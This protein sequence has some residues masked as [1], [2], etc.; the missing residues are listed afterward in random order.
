M[1]EYP[2]NEMIQK[3]KDALFSFFKEKYNWITYVVL[4]VLVFLA[5]RIRSLNLDKL[6]DITTGTWTLGPDLDPFLFLRWAKYIV[7][8]G[9]LFAVDTM[10]YVPLGYPTDTELPLLAYSIAWFHKVAVIFGSE[11]VTQSAVLFPVFIF[12]LTV[13]AFFFFVRK[14]FLDFLGKTKANIIALLSSFFLIILPDFLPRTIAGIPEK[15]SLAFFFM[16]L[17]FYLFLCAWKTERLRNK[18]VL[19]VLAGISTAGMG[20]TWGGVGYIFLT[21]G[22]TVLISFLFGGVDKN[23]TYTYAVWAI[24]SFAFMSPFASRY[25]LSGVTLGVITGL[26]YF[27]L[28]VIIVHLI[29]TETKVKN[30]IL[31]SRI[32]FIEK[33]PLPILSVIISLILGMIIGSIVV[34]PSFVPQQIHIIAANLLEP[35][36]S[37]LIQTVAENRQPFF[38]E[39]SSGFGPIIKGFPTFFWLFFAGSIYLF[40]LIVSPLFGKKEKISLVSAYTLLI[41]GVVFSRYSSSNMFNGANAISS[42]FYALSIIIFILVM[43][44]Y[45]YKKYNSE[46]EQIASINI[47]PILLLVL[48]IFSLISARGAIR[49]VLVLVPSAAVLASCFVVCLSLRVLEIKEKEKKF[50]PLIFAIIIL[51]SSAYSAYFFYA[52]TS[53]VAAN[54]APY[55]YTFQWQKAM[56][57]VREST[58]ENAVFGHWWDYGYWIQSIGERATILDGGNAQSY[59]NH[60]MGRYALTGADNRKALEFLYAHN[61]TN[62]L[63]DSTDIGKYGA[64]STIGSNVNYDR[65]SFIP[66]LRKDPANQR[67]TKSGFI[68]VYQSNGYGLDDDIIYEVNGTKIFL[69]K[70]KAA[71]IGVYAEFNSAGKLLTNPTAVYADQQGKQYSIPLRY[72]YDTEFRDFNSGIEGGIFIVPTVASE[73]Q[74]V[75]VDPLGSIFYLSKRTVKSQLARLYLYGEEDKGFNLVHREDNFLVADLKNQNAIKGDF[76]DYQGFRGPIKI[77]EIN[78]P[79]DIEFK[80]EYVDTFYPEEISAVS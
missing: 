23:R 24:S 44:F 34:S 61:A 57:W 65:S 55:E 10:R 17:A 70:G 3:R 28:F 18:L 30:Y 27:T 75:S 63:I 56:Q 16:F 14:V 52:Q 26:A 46:R 78:Y 76:I 47:A 41:S 80:P 50:I 67:E 39:W 51:I 35:A 49:L 6:R 73:N 33:I 12:A 11:S 15:E 64:F 48:F 77:W 36:Q 43:G 54:Y 31:N 1:E 69:P 13:I 29:I 21:I 74:K 37:R 68:Y 58:S 38:T 59:W 66:S 19:S 20:L 71:L 60:M 72:G 5:V 22:M 8:H 25:T 7:E 42:L 40:Y 32:K 79:K 62:F 53:N 9:T 45:Y 2:P 4:A